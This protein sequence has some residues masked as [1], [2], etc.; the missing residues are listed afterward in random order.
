[1]GGGAIAIRMR[2]IKCSWVHCSISE[3]GQL[4]DFGHDWR[5][6]AYAMIGIY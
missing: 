6:F 2:L 3:T 1:M 5:S 4:L